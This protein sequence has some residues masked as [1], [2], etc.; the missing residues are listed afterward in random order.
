[1]MRDI[2]SNVRI[3]EGSRCSEVLD[4]ITAA[5]SVFYRQQTAGSLQPFPA[6]ARTLTDLLRS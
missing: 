3:V 6:R 2:I 1:M 4:V 5:G